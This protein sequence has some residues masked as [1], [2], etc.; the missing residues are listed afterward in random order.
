[1]KNILRIK[2]IGNRLLKVSKISFSLSVLL[3]LLMIFSFAISFGNNVSA[4]EA[5]IIDNYEVNVQANID[6]SFNITEKI[7][8]DFSAD[9]H[10]IFRAIPKK[11]GAVRYTISKINVVDEKYTIEGD[12]LNLVIKIGDANTLINGK[13]TYNIAYT[14]TFSKD[15]NTTADIVNLD[16]LGNAWDTQITHATINFYYPTKTSIPTSYQVFTGVYGSKD[17]TGSTVS[18]EGDNLKII[19][20]APLANFQGMTLL[21]KFPDNTFSQAKELPEPFSFNEYNAEISI[22][23]DKIVKYNES[24]NLKINDQSESIYYNLPLLTQD[25]QQLI[26]RNVKLNGKK[27]QVEDLQGVFP[28]LLTKE[29]LNRIEYTI[30]YNL[31]KSQAENEIP[32]MLFSNYREITISNAKIIINS[33][34]KAPLSYQTMVTALKADGKADSITNDQGNKIAIDIKTPLRTGEGIFINVVYPPNSFGFVLAPFTIISILLGILLLI[35]SIYWFNKYGKDDVI[36]PVIEFYPPEGLSSGALGYVA[37][38]VVHPIDIS[39]MLLYWASHNH[40]HFIATSK[41]DFNIT[42][43]SDLDELHPQWEQ[44]AFNKLK[45]LIFDTSGTLSKDEL[46][47]GFYK[48]AEKIRPAIPLF[49]KNDKSLDDKLSVRISVLLCSI[50]SL[51]MGLFT[52]LVTY[53]GLDQFVP[54]LITGV[55]AF[56]IVSVFYGVIKTIENGWHKRSKPSNYAMSFF[57]VG[58]GLLVVL[59]YSVAAFFITTTVQPH[60]IIFTLFSVIVSVLISAFTVKRSSYGQKILESIVG[61]KEFLKVAEKERLEALIEENPEY[62]YQILPYALVLNVSDVWESKFRGI[63]MV[64]PSWYQGSYAGYIFSYAALSSFAHQ[65]SSTLTHYTAPPQASGSGG[66]SGGGGGGFSGGGGGGGGGGSW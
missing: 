41:D 19:N 57:T 60:A 3:I 13:K 35:L 27:L 2:L 30:Y 21:A 14:L 45:D 20:N 43:N 50:C 1:M 40:L 59:V 52:G 58:F 4:Q 39:S 28:I 48:V 61:F 42:L 47:T 32:L 62:Y 65:T 64:E 11:G 33:L 7:S 9:R 36:S 44:N 25:K 51:W 66:F 10:G 38:R 55:S 16:L 23:K 5:F 54:G 46:Q 49:F 6:N 34:F 24:F 29:G 8:V 22:A 18:N 12:A 37:D 15:L 53:A 63:N 26:I 56:A 17:E 31:G